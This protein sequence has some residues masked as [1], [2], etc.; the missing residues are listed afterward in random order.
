MSKTIEMADIMRALE[1][2]HG[3]PMLTSNQ[4]AELARELNLAAPAVERQP[5]AA[6][7]RYRQNE[8]SQWE[9]WEPCSLSYGVDMAKLLPNQYEMKLLYTS[10]P[11]PAAVVLPERKTT[12]PEDGALDRAHKR[13]YNACIDDTKELNQ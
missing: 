8:L 13:G 12:D 10:P 4:C 9:K 5:A 7:V 3:A 6:L 1:K 11:A 2:V